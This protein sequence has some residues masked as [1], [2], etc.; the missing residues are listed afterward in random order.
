[1]PACCRV[2]F[3]EVGTCQ[4]VSS[5][6]NASV[7]IKEYECQPKIVRLAIDGPNEHG[8]CSLDHSLACKRCFLKATAMLG[9]QASSLLQKRRLRS[10]KS[11]GMCDEACPIRI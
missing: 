7:A 11:P 2:V 9:R 5:G 6:Q 10:W 8:V 4:L 3:E 1:M